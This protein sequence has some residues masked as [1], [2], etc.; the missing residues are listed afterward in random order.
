MGFSPSILIVVALAECWLLLAVPVFAQPSLTERVVRP[1][2][3]E[4]GSLVVYPGVSQSHLRFV[5]AMLAR[6]VRV[7][8]GFEEVAQEPE[9]PVGDLAKVPIAQ[10]T[11]LIGLTIARA[12][13]ALV[14]ADPRYSWREYDDVLVIRPVG[15]WRDP[16]HFLHETLGPIELKAKRG[17]VIVRELYDQKGLP[18][19]WSI[20]GVLGEPPQGGRDLNVPISVTLPS[21]NMLD[22]LN[23]VTK[24]HGQLSW[25]IEYS[26]GY[27]EF[28]YSCVLLVTFEGKFGGIGPAACSEY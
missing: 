3:R 18:M 5:V 6:S 4:D 21:A 25:L 20:G 15:A 14:A 1:I 7:P 22:V 19:K 26:R 16:T 10:R 2:G 12:L 9:E 8:I 24:S 28:R 11:P 13:D 27:A 23:G 17:I